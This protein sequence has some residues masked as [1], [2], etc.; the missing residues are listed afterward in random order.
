MSL[1]MLICAHCDDG[2]IGYGAACRPAHVADTKEKKMQATSPPF[3]QIGG[4]FCAG[5]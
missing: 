2:V 1:Q 5:A 3:E 4:K